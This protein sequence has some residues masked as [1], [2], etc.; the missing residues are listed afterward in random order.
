MREL[1]RAV[2]DDPLLVANVARSEAYR[3]E[4]GASLLRLTW[5][6]H[7]AFCG[8]CGRRRE[9]APGGSCKHGQLALHFLAELDDHARAC[10]ELLAVV[11]AVQHAKRGGPGGTVATRW[12]P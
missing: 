3:A 10:R 4:A 2:L 1:A 8:E 9:P 11:R 12:K 7:R 5:E 6:Q